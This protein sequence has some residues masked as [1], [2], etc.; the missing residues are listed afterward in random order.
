MQMM[1]LMAADLVV[2]LFLLTSAVYSSKIRFPDVTTGISLI[3]RML[4][5]MQAGK[6]LRARITRDRRHY[7]LL[8]RILV[9]QYVL[10]HNKGFINLRFVSN[11]VQNKTYTWHCLEK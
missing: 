4:T 10:E 6:S 5:Q 3:Y 7:I 8:A 11:T 1:H 9:A 2:E